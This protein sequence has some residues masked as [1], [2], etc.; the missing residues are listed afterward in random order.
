VNPAKVAWRK[1][2]EQ[3]CRTR[4]VT[5]NYQLYMYVGF[6]DSFLWLSGPDRRDGGDKC[7]AHVFL[8]EFFHLTLSF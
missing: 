1:K 6:F 5:I 4:V 3:S 2:N 8:Q 7:F